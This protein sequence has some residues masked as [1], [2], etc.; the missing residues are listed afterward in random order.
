VAD[1]QI[2]P[3]DPDLYLPL[4]Q[5]PAADLGLL[6]RTAAAPG[7]LATTL[8]R[9]L[10]ALDRDVPLYAMAPM[11]EL[12][13][14]QTARSRVSAFLMG[15]FGALALLLAGLGIYGV[16]SYSVAQRGHEIGVRMALGARR[17]EVFRLVL[18]QAL[19]LTAIG[20]ALGL[21]GA[22]ALT[23]LLAGQLY[24]LSPNDP[25]T[26][27]AVALLLAGA[28]L[29]AGWLPAHRATRVDPLVALRHD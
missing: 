19:G 4:A 9:E 26:Y 15:S 24:G 1:P 21:A 23:R 22:L 20:M 8:R 29:A 12:A 13:A 25:S 7:T 14:A 10:T 27:A 28:A 11:E 16:I 2:S 3:E 5:K 17:G 6:V 18:A